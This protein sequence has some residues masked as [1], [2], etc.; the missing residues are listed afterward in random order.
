VCT[1]I[2]NVVNV[3]NVDSFEYHAIRYI[4]YFLVR[5]QL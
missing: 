4:F 2:C 3:V 5:L 1:Y